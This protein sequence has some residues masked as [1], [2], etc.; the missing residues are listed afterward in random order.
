MP[1]LVA[2]LALAGLLKIAHLGLPQWHL[3]FWFAA[4]VM[5]ALFAAI[6][7]WPGLLNGAGMFLASWLYFWALDVTD[8]RLNRPLHYLIL[9]C[10][11]LT[12][13]GGRFWIDIVI[14]GVGL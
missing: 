3:A 7:F 8:N 5:A 2:A 13:L 9:V 11:M 1:T 12:L 4:L 6:G 14:Y 10:G